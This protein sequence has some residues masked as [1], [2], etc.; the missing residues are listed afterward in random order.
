MVQIFTFL[1]ALSAA[2]SVTAAPPHFSKR[3]AQVISDSTTQW[4]AACVSF[5]YAPSTCE[6]GLSNVLSL[7]LGQGGGWAEMQP[8]S[9]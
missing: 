1:F 2:G 4:E 5:V 3:I 7:R 8:D 6:G 9:C